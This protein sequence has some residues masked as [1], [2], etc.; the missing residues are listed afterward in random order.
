M[1]SIRS[2][3]LSPRGLVLAAAV[4]LVAAG[5]S[6]LAAAAA[7]G[8]SAGRGEGGYVPDFVAIVRRY[9]ASGE[10]FRIEGVCKSA[11]TLFLGIR[12]VC[13]ERG[14]TLMFHGGHDIAENVTGPD[15][16]ASRAGLYRYN[17][18]LRR[19]LL[20]GHF[21]DTDAFHSLPGAAIID[22]FGYRECLAKQ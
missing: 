18:P 16:R 5:P 2:A 21:M 1:G 14:A 7:E 8:S 9:N 11:C 3:R 12:N 13:V 4:A 17:E 10:P 15:T 6:H 19:Y 20:D 22:R